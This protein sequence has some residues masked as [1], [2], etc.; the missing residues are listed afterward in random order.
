M[1][2]FCL[3]SKVCASV[4]TAAALALFA[5]CSASGDEEEI[6]PTMPN[7]HGNSS[8]TA[9]SGSSSDTTSTDTSATDS[10][11]L[12]SALAAYENLEWAK[13]GAFS[14]NS[15]KVNGFFITTTEV[16][17]AA[18]I[19][20]MGSAPAQEYKGD[21]YP[22]ENVSWYDA[23]LFC[24][25]LSKKMKMDTVYVYDSAAEG[26]LKNVEID[27]SANGVRLPTELEWLFAYDVESDYQYYWGVEEASKYAYYG[28]SKGPAKVATLKPNDNG[29]Y[30]MSGNV[31]E[32]VNDWFGLLDKVDNATGPETGEY[33]VI[34]GGGWN[35][36]V[37]DLSGT[38]RDKKDPGYK[39]VTL[40][41]RVVYSLED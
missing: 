25:A 12:P 6:A 26:V 33:R 32:W 19:D 27:Y 4:L 10:F 34:R 35:D 21:S 13:V 20:V 17:Q 23:A 28:Q 22:V 14:Y 2:K 31:A 40:G 3:C 36:V 15:I 9:K 24:N 41:F 29:L 38:S 30:D 16:T 1:K 7:P 18:Y 8:S 11:G 37:K 39:S 5:S